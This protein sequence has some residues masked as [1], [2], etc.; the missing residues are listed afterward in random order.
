[1]KKRVS[2]LRVAVFAV[3]IM[4][5]IG[6]APTI[7][8]VLFDLTAS[9]VMSMIDDSGQLP[10]EKERQRSGFDMLD[11]DTQRQLIAAR[12]YRIYAPVAGASDEHIERAER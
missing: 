11:P 3:L 4:L 6:L 12:A 1:M 5:F 8:T 9:T 7:A 2:I 10:H